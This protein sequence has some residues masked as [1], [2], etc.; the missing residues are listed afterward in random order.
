MNTRQV[1]KFATYLQKSAQVYAP[2]IKNG[3][4]IV[5]PIE[6]ADEIS[7]VNEVPLTTFKPVLLPHR[8]VLFDYKKQTV[9]TEVKPVQARVAFGM[10]MPDLKAVCLFHQVFERDPYYQEQFKKSLL[11]GMAKVTKTLV[12][13]GPTKDRYT[14]DIL[15]HRIFDIFLGQLKK[16]E[17]VVLTGSKK[18]QQVLKRFGIKKFEHIEFEGYIKEAP[19]D[20]YLEKYRAVV[21]KSHAKKIWDYWGSRCLACGKCGIDCPMCFCFDIKDE[22]DEAVPE[23]GQRIRKWTS[24]FYNDFSAIGG[25]SQSFLPTNAKRIENWYLHKFVRIPRQYQVSGCVNCG[26]CDRVC[27]AGITRRDVFWSLENPDDAVPRPRPPKPVQT[28]KKK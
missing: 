22:A 26:R 24:C 3:G 21:V 25:G 9:L 1:L 12:I 6:S 10:T 28:I 13:H 8:Q 19:N 20:P 7:L 18:G 23:K 14:K 5:Q 11:I 2:V 4:L 27:P 15:K 16:D 17:W